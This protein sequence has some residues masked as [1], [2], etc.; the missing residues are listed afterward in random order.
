VHLVSQMPTP[1]ATPATT[2]T[3]TPTPEPDVWRPDRTFKRASG[4]LDKLLRVIGDITIWPTV[5]LGP[6][7]APA[8]VVLWGVVRVQR[9]GRKSDQTTATAQRGPTVPVP[10]SHLAEQAHQFQ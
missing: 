1:T 8:A 9:K 10:Q 2:P 7:L 3:P 6:F 5:V 4:I